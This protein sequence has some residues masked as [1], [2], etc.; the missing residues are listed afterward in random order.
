MPDHVPRPP[1]APPNEPL[2]EVP[3]TYIRLPP[4]FFP[5]KPEEKPDVH[6][7]PYIRRPPMEPPQPVID[8]VA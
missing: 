4:D 3:D 8:R 1:K 6:V 2:M 5:P 7:P